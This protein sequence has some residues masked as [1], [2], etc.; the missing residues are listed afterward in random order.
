MKKIRFFFFFVPLLFLFLFAGLFSGCPL[1]APNI[2]FEGNNGTVNISI[3]NPGYTDSFYMDSTGQF[4]YTYNADKYLLVREAQFSEGGNIYATTF[5]TQVNA[6]AGVAVEADIG[7]LQQEINTESSLITDFTAQA[8]GDDY[9]IDCYTGNS[10]FGE[11]TLLQGNGDGEVAGNFTVDYTTLA[12]KINPRAN[13]QGECG[14]YA[15]APYLYLNG[16]VWIDSLYVEIYMDAYNAHFEWDGEYEN[17]LNGEINIT[18]E[19]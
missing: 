10:D 14:I 19:H 15:L 11:E 4:S 3:E 8:E 9:L 12:G 6:M 2:T 13:A 1:A 5:P 7:Y 18:E 16:G 17:Y